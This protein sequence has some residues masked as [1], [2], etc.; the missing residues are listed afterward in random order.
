MG[1]GWIVGSGVGESG[2][3]RGCECWA[4]EELELMLVT[5]AV[6]IWVQAGLRGM[7]PA[8]Q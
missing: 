3:G 7:A 8:G 5:S 4:R 2:D 6:F 1:V